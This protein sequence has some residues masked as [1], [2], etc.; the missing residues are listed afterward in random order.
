MPSPE[1]LPI[2]HIR[3]LFGADRV[4]VIAPAGRILFKSAAGPFGLKPKD[5][6]LPPL[7]QS[8]CN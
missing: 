3:V 2:V 4:Y 8:L 5:I 7:Q 1:G 6:E